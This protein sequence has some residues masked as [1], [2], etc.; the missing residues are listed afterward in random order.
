VTI[1]K[2]AQQQHLFLERSLRVLLLKILHQILD[3]LNLFCRHVFVY[4]YKTAE[5]EFIQGYWA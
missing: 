5:H 3:T 4:H 1:R 2:A